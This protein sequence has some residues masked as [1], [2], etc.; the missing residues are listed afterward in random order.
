MG[1]LVSVTVTLGRPAPDYKYGPKRPSDP[2][3]EPYLI[4]NVDLKHCDIV[5]LK[6]LV[7][8]LSKLMI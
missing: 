8:S 3:L 1:G 4:C 2:R 5:L 7:V 6:T